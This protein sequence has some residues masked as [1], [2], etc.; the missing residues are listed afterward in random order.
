MNIE[1]RTTVKAQP[2]IGKKD[3]SI[4][5]FST[6]PDVFTFSVT[7]DIDGNQETFST[8][9]YNEYIH[10]SSIN[11]TKIKT[12]NALKLLNLEDY[13]SFIKYLSVIIF[14]NSQD[15]HVE[16]NFTKP[17]S[18]EGE[19]PQVLYESK[20]LQMTIKHNEGSYMLRLN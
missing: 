16:W 6:H 9:F 11:M 10:C 18:V 13:T 12:N 14:K 2:L 4:K 17:V 8:T 1:F 5:T 7:C 20:E 3:I 15:I 19:T